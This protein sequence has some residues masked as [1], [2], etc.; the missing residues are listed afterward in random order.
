MA[1]VAIEA[2]TITELKQ[3]SEQSEV[4]LVGAIT[5]DVVA[6]SDKQWVKKCSG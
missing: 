5:K 1:A 2:S 3:S 4:Q 6:G